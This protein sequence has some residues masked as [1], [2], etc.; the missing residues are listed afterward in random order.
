MHFM[1][2]TFLDRV[3]RNLFTGKAINAGGMGC[4]TFGAGPGFLYKTTTSEVQLFLEFS[5]CYKVSVI[6][7][8]SKMKKILVLP[9]DQADESIGF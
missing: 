1:P 2:R 8:Y 5:I 4:L 9:Q 6:I 7:F 3:K